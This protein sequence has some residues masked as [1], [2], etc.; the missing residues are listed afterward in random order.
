M[1]MIAGYIVTRDDRVFGHGETPDAAVA[2]AIRALKLQDRRGDEEVPLLDGCSTYPVTA[3]LLAEIEAVGTPE[4][5]GR[6]P[7][8]IFSE[9]LG[10][11]VYLQCTVPERQAAEVAAADAAEAARE[12]LAAA[13][14]TLYGAEW[15]SPLSRELG[16]ALRTVQ[17][18]ASGDVPV[19][20]RILTAEIPTLAQRAVDKGLPV[21][22]EARAAEVR[23]LAGS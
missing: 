20:E 16:V 9:A 11:R 2:D 21:Q 5:W 13:G 7:Q 14:E 18:W 10:E 1:V 22:L 19:P 6:W 15:V 17:R 3:A 8:R 4:E 23:R 12:A